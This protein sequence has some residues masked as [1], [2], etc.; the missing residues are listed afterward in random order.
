MVPTADI[1]DAAAQV[2]A[3]LRLH[4]TV[5]DGI[6]YFRMSDSIQLDDVEQVRRRLQRPTGIQASWRVS[7]GGV[8]EGAG[9]ADDSDALGTGI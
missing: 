6:I 4:P 1:C 8:F 3:N 2:L 5:V 9:R 7:D